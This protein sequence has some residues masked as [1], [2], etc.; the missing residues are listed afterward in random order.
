[1]VKMFFIRVV[2]GLTASL[3]FEIEE[4]DLKIAF[5]HGDIEEETYIEQLE[6]FSVKSKKEAICK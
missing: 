1:M 2:M 5:L 4:L 6:G 3:T